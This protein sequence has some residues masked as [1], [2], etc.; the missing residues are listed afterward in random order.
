MAH[1]DLVNSGLGFEPI[2][3]LW[4]A[5]CADSIVGLLVWQ[6]GPKS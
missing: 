2:S 6:I 1:S 3:A 4:L 5:N